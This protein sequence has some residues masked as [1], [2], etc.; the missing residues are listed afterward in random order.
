[1]KLLRYFLF[2]GIFVACL[3]LGMVEHIDGFK[4]VALAIAWFTFAMSI[5]ASLVV[6]NTTTEGLSEMPSMSA[7]P[8]IDRSFDF[9]VI[10]F[11]MFHGYFVTGAAYTFS[12][13]VCVGVYMA[14][15]KAKKSE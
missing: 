8:W 11:L 6:G 15:E 5:C 9:S 13:L 14:I 3:W 7:P 4:N 1:M 2:N 12:S 10:L